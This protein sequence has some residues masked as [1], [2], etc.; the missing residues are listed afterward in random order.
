MDP[1]IV[2]QIILAVLTGVISV[3][4]LGVSGL[5]K[6]GLKYLETKWGSEKFAHAKEIAAT[7]VRSLEQTHA[8]SNLSGAKKKEIAILQVQEWAKAAK[9]DLS[10][11][12]T[13]RLIEEAVQIMNN[14]LGNIFT[15]DA[16]EVVEEK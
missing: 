7:I 15:V 9:I 1:E 16:S 6:M 10:Y 2:N 14:E 4:F 3:F 13:D 12:D 8:Y 11:E 5:V